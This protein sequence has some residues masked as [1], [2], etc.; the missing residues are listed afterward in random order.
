MNNREDKLLQLPMNQTIVQTLTREII[1]GDYDGV[2]IP[3]Q[4]EIAERFNVSRVTVREAINELIHR[5]LLITQRGKG[6]F[7][8]RL[9]KEDFLK[10]T[11]A[12]SFSQLHD[13]EK[14]QS[15]VLEISDINCNEKLEKEL[16]TS[17][18]CKIVKIVRLRMFDGIP[19]EYS[20][21]YLNRKYIGDIKFCS[22]ELKTNSLYAQLEEKSGIVPDYIN[23]EIRAVYCP[24]EVSRLFGI[25]QDP[26]LRI[27]RYTY[28]NK[29]ELY[30]YCEVYQRSD[31]TS[32]RIRLKGRD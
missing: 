27:K 3:T 5:G 18:D 19:H 15:R 23:E 2:M 8:R 31:V 14:I 16:S 1:N 9:P 11:V 29:D 20:I 7:V 6:T 30:E 17:K 21:S 32:K 4:V 25:L 22:D 28:N 13:G 24:D 10:L 12:I 26:V